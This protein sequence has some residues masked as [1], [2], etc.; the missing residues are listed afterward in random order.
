MEPGN[1]SILSDPS[2]RN[3]PALKLFSRNNFWF[4]QGG[5]LQKLLWI[6]NFPLAKLPLETTHF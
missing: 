4:I 2:V 3:M 5:R 1:P 6:P